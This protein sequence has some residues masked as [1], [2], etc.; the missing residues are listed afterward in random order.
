M[1]QKV[2]IDIPLSTDRGRSKAMQIA[3]AINGVTS[4]NIDKEKSH[5]VVIGEGID[6]FQLM[7]C[8][9]RRFSMTVLIAPKNAPKAPSRLAKDP[10][11]LSDEEDTQHASKASM[12]AP[13]PTAGVPRRAAEV[14]VPR[15]AE[16]APVPTA[17]VEK[18]VDVLVPT[19]EVDKTKDVPVPTDEVEKVQMSQLKLMRML[20]RRVKLILSLTLKKSV[21]SVVAQMNSSSNN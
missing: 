7:K 21:M 17:Q 13:E 20:V 19:A 18:A 5:L 11:E 15:S 8:L 12:K 2:V 10:N 9:K 3:V 14:D 1:K 6:S 16:Y 4:V